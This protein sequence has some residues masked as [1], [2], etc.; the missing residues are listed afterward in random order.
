MKA[1]YQELEQKQMKPFDSAVERI[2]KNLHFF[3]ENEFKSTMATIK[4]NEI[5]QKYD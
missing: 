5:T 4:I 3:K 1:L 2:I